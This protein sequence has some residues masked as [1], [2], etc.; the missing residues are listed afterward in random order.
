MIQAMI[1]K[2]QVTIHQVVKIKINKSKKKN[3][4]PK[5]LQNNQKEIQMIQISVN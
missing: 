1:Q 5:Q 3:L 4:K 2:I